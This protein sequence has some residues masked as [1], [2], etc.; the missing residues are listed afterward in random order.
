MPRTFDIDTLVDLVVNRARVDTT[1]PD[2]NNLRNG[3]LTDA[4]LTQAIDGLVVGQYNEPAAYAEI[5]RKVLAQVGN[6]PEIAALA[7][8][9]IFRGERLLPLTLGRELSAILIIKELEH[10]IAALPDGPRKMRCRSLLQYHQGVFYD[11]CGRFA[12]AAEFQLRSA[13]EASR[14]DD[15]SGMA[16]ALFMNKIYCLKDALRTGEPIAESIFPDI[17]RG[18][19]ALVT[20]MRGFILEVQ[21]AEANGPVYMIEACIWLNR[22]HPDWNDWVATAL[23]AAEKLGTSWDLC[24]EFVRA[25]DMDRRGDPLAE[26]A[27]NAVAESSDANERRAAALLILARRAMDKGRAEKAR[28][29]VA[30]MPEQGAQHVIAV[31]NRRVK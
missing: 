29:I 14:F 2:P 18:F 10:G 19:A 1:A 26:E 5:G 4:L 31:A 16:I 22:I 7:Q 17:E 25:V 21:W 23:A 28:E 12:L 8:L 13:Q 20:T 11:A 30:R 9:A 15:L 24:A 6:L 3:W 27:L